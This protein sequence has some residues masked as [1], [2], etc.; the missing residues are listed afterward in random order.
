MRATP[1]G[2]MRVC[3]HDSSD[4]VRMTVLAGRDGH[5]EVLEVCMSCPREHRYYKVAGL[6]DRPDG[7]TEGEHWA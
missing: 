5:P 3:R 2:T 7:D 1:S 6:P 4:C